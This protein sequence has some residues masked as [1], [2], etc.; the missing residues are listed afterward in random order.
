VGEFPAGAG[1]VSFRDLRLT[2]E[3]APAA[4]LAPFQRRR[5]TLVLL[6]GDGNDNGGMGKA[7]LAA[8]EMEHIGLRVVCSSL[9]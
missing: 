3:E 4:G 9:C 5:R 8:A 2:G 6:T 1:D 7:L